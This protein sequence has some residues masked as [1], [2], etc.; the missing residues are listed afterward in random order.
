M[1]GGTLALP[2]GGVWK[3]HGATVHLGGTGHTASIAE[4]GGARFSGGMLTATRDLNTPSQANPAGLGI[5]ISSGENL[6]ATTIT[7]GHAIQTGPNGNQSIARYFDLAPTNNSGLGATLTFHYNDDELN[8]LAET[9]LEFFRSTDGGASWSERG[10]DGRDAGA[11]TVTLSGVDALSQW[12]LGSEHSPLPVEL[13]RFEAA[14]GDG[15]VQLAWRTASETNNAGFHVQRRRSGSEWTRVGFVEGHGTTAEPQTYAFDDTGL[16]YAAD[17]LH[18]RLRQVDLDGASHYSASVEVAI[19]APKELA[20]RGNYPNPFAR[21]TTI[22]YEVPE[23]GNV[24][25]AVYDMLGRRVEMLAD[26]YQKAGRKEVTFTARD[27]SSG[28]YFVRLTAG[29]MTQMRKITVVR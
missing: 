27:L 8:G 20:L 2:N 1:N 29:N 6:G 18:Y 5:V 19:A 23:N 12:T 28:I 13:T 17:S 15:A 26:E 24:Q 4:T 9:A 22:R 21:Q 14:V 11:N 7:R 3:L 16:P 10:H 25:L